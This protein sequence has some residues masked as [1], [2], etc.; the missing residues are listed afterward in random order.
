M[1]WIL[2]FLAGLCEVGWAVGLKYTDGFS[3]PLP[4]VLTLLS[5]LVSIWLL[6]IALKTIPLSVAY[7]VWVGI[8][9]MGTVV[10]GVLWL[11]EPI[12]LAKVLSLLFIA[13]GIVGLK[14]SA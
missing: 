7:A 12:F 3:K 2:L 4:T 11:D 13:A 9:V 5:M 14:L 6:G 8:G 10:F 1:A